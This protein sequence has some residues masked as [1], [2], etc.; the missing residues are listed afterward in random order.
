MK[1]IHIDTATIDGHERIRLFFPYDPEIIELVKTLPGA[2]WHPEMK[3]WHIAPMLGPAIKLKNRF[4]GKLDFLPVPVVP[5]S[6]KPEEGPASGQGLKVPPEF[7]KTM[8]LR[9]Y[10]EKTIKSYFSMIK[11]FMAFYKD[12]DLKK[13]TDEDIREYLLYL[14]DVKKVSQSYENQAIN[15]I[16]FYYERVLG[17]PTQKYYLQRPKAEKR[18]PSVLSV[19]E[20]RSLLKHARN[21]K[22]RTALSLIY[23]AGLRVGELIN[24]KLTD[25]DS[26]RGN[27]LIRQG[28]GKKDRV[29]LLSANIL[30][31]L[32][33]YY[34]KYRPKVWV[35][36]GETGGQY[37]ITSVQTVFRRAKDAAGIAKPATVHTLR[38]SFATHLLER[39]TDLRYIQE[40]L[41][42]Q[43]VKTTEIYTHITNKGMKNIKSPFDDMEL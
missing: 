15:A 8:K 14:V 39:G 9:Q 23:S 5:V 37:S 28:K 43:S 7:A 26:A 35:F 30:E 41:G 34:R 3:C 1:S 21:L 42:H 31:L 24:L 6:E 19:E 10:S 40:L 16:K 11:L 36:E 38:H 12:R 20:V 22:H 4:L 32:R 29:S 17:R 33:E 2:R 18:L 27:I 13:L 25:I